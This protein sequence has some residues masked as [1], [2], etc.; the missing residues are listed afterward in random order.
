MNNEGPFGP[1][2]KDPIVMTYAEKVEFG[3]ALVEE[4]IKEYK[5]KQ[6]A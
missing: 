4:Q 2:V 1:E 5:E 3:N 6:N